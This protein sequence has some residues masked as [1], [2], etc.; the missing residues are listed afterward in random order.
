[1]SSV[2]V[3]AGASLCAL[4]A[5]VLGVAALLPSFLPSF[6]PARKGFPR[7]TL[8]LLCP[9]SLTI[10]LPALLSASYRFFLLFPE[11][12]RYL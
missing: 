11:F 9:L 8:G 5:V 10:G 7:Q 3:F 12:I 6:G 4:V 2:H 1:M